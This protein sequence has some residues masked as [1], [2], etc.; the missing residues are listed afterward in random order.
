VEAIGFAQMA[1][2]AGD[3]PTLPW[4]WA[5]LRGRY[6]STSYCL[7]VSLPKASNGLLLL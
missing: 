6:Q 1:R 4:Y 2:M 5:R 7:S 3:L